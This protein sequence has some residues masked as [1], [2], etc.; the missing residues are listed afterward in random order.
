ME[1][2]LNKN[3]CK[4]FQ[5]FAGFAIIQP[6]VISFLGKQFFKI[7]Q[8]NLTLAFN[9]I[10][11]ESKILDKGSRFG[12]NIAIITANHPDYN[13]V[14][15]VTHG[16]I[17]PLVI[18]GPGDC[19]VAGIFANGAGV[20]TVLGGKSYINTVYT[21]IASDI[22]ICFLG[23]LS[24][25][26]NSEV[27]EAIGVPDILFVPIGGGDLLSPQDAYKLAVSLEPSLIIP[28]DYN[29]ASLKIFLKEAGGDKVAPVE[30]LTL[31]KKDL[32]GKQGE[33]VVLQHA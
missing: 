28:M 7:S 27:R 12:A 17:I 13:G 2:Y 23:A 25:D 33:I 8:G 14:E 5:I 26:L 1:L 20:S 15:M 22:K 3:L 10:S 9:P 4:G 31:K 18:D 6:M 29:E 21:L 16:D 19:E 32:E 30:K 24:K 11:K